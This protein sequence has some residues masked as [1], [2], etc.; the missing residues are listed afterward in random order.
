MIGL[1]HA[2][3]ADVPESDYQKLATL[4]SCVKHLTSLDVAAYKETAP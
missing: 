2:L 1:R 3:R 4:D